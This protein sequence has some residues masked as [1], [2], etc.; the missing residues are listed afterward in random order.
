MN[1]KIV[2]NKHNKNTYLT[3]FEEK[4]KR[5]K[6][7]DW[8]SVPLGVATLLE[9]YSDV[10]DDNARFAL[11][12]CDFEQKIENFLPYFSEDVVRFMQSKDS[13]G[14]VLLAREVK[15]PSSFGVCE[16]NEMGKIVDIEEKPIS[17][18]SNMN[19]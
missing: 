19:F 6:I 5:V 14:C 16:F 4:L 1:L 11:M 17:P 8:I 2:H 10:E 12:S 3:S 9:R 13:P 15:D 7:V 18:K